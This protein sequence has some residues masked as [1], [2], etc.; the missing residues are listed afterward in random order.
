MSDES[1]KLSLIVD[2]A[3]LKGLTEAIT[4]SPEE[5]QEDKA[6]LEKSLCTKELHERLVNDGRHKEPRL[7]QIILP[8]LTAIP[9]QG[10][11]ATNVKV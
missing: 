8:G 6:I 4:Q 3:L 7:T 9:E 2:I 1:K 10:L 11:N 5:I